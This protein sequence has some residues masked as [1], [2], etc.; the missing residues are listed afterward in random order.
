[1]DGLEELS[2]HPPETVPDPES[3]NSKLEELTEKFAF[4]NNI[5][6]STDPNPSKSKSKCL[7]MVGTMTEVYPPPLCLYGKEVPWVKQASHLGHELHQLCNMEQDARTKR[8]MYIDNSTNIRELFN[9]AHPFQ[10]L[11]NLYGEGAGRAFRCWGQ[12][13]KRVWEV[14]LATHTYIVDN[15]NFF[16]GLLRSASWEVRVLAN[17]VAR[18][19]QT[20]TGKNLSNLEEEF[21]VNPWLAK[22]SDLKVK[23]NVAEVPSDE[24]WRLPLLL[25]ILEERRDRRM[26]GEEGE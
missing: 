2:R 20:V 19:K 1:M 5:V 9:F 7:F 17:I 6:F 18:N 11:W 13:V 4:R 22:P 3:K 12:T 23:F 26:E 25:E 15:L 14:P 8:A 21:G 10:I 24:K 16:R